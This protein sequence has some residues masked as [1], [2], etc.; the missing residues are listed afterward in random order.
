MIKKGELT[1]TEANADDVMREL[2]SNLMEA[3][4]EIGKIG[5]VTGENRL[6]QQTGG[7]KGTPGIDYPEAPKNITEANKIDFPKGF[8]DVIDDA[9]KFDSM[10]DW[11][12]SH[13]TDVGSRDIAVNQLHQ[14]VSE[15]GFQT[16]DDFWKMNK[17]FP[18]QPPKAGIDYPEPPKKSLAP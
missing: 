6:I 4:E 11:I 2:Q 17:K 3:K 10:E 8:T 7:K 1:P 14:A 13:I 16:L 18:K 5:G 15:M 12:G 9:N